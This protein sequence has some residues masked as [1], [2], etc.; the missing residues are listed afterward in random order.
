MYQKI[1]IGLMGLTSGGVSVLANFIPFAFLFVP[2]LVFGIFMY[3]QYKPTRHSWIIIGISTLAY[4]AAMWFVVYS[5]L[6]DGNYQLKVFTSRNLLVL[7][8]IAGGT[9]L[10]IGFR[11]L[12]IINTVHIFAL[13]LLSAIIMF[14]IPTDYVGWVGRVPNVYILFPVW[15]GVIAF[16]LG[17][18][19]KTETYQRSYS[20]QPPN[21]S[22]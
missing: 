19:S 20:N 4:F 11:L 22:I 2:G 12:R 5:G 21:L 1:K 15:Q 6:G 7:G 8:G 17:F 10:G 13:G 16:Y 18:V 9:I 3:R 14:F